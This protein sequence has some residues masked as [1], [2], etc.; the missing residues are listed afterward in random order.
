MIIQLDIFNFKALRAVRLPLREY[1]LL[2]GPNGSGKSSVFDAVLLVR[3][4]LRGEGPEQTIRATGAETLNELTHC[5][6]GG[7]IGLSFVLKRESWPYLRYTLVIGHEESRGVIVEAEALTRLTDGED[8]QITDGR[9]EESVNFDLFRHTDAAVQ[10]EKLRKHAS[11]KTKN[12]QRILYKTATGADNFGRL[13]LDASGKKFWSVQTLLSGK[14]QLTLKYAPSEKGME[15]ANWVKETLLT[16]PMRVQLD[17]AAVRESGSPEKTGKELSANGDNFANA[18]Y[19]FEKE[20]PEDFA[21]WVRHLNRFFKEIHK[22][23]IHIRPE[24]QRRTVFAVSSTGVK[25]PQYLLSDGTLR[26]M[27]LTLLAYY[28]MGPRLLL[29]EEPENG[30]H[31]SA[32][33]GVLKP[34]RVMNPEQQVIFASHSPVVLANFDL[35]DVLVFRKTDFGTELVYAKDHPK[36]ATWTSEIDKGSLLAAGIF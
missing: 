26:F 35:D 30:L 13:A 5:A 17:I 25:V 21:L 24:N 1:Q 15:Y 8:Y 14:K 36:I 4:S 3:D 27:A 29:I 34:F 11:R 12:W 9:E 16:V 20:K 23:Q 28:R 6:E 22:V 19:Q 33:E 32:V 10:V 18:V 31:P 2:V 7:V